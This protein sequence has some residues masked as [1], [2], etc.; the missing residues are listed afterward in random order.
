MLG[1]LGGSCLSPLGLDGSPD[2]DNLLLF[3]PFVSMFVVEGLG[4]LSL[5]GSLIS[6]LLGRFSRRVLPSEP[7]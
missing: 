3:L 5:G 4:S 1:R 6:G 7:L 2:V